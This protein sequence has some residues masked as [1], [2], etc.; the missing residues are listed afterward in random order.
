MQA[1]IL[2]RQ[3]V[4]YGPNACS[5]RQG[6]RIG[7]SQ[8]LRR[9]VKEDLVHYTG[10]QSCP[11]DLRAGFDENTC[12]LPPPQLFHGLSQVRTGVASAS[13]WLLQFRRGDGATQGT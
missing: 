12:D 9:I 2:N 6:E 7:A 3:G 4:P 13:R 5:A 1:D 10:F 11:V 8:K